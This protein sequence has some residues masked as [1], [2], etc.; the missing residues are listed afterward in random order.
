MLAALLLGRVARALGRFLG[1]LLA[2]LERLLA[3][4][5][6]LGLDVVGDRAEL[7]VLYA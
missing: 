3:G 5:L 2:A 1:D 4:L 7:A 6:G